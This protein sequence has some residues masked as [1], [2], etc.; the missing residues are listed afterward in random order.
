SVANERFAHSSLDD[1]LDRAAWIGIKASSP[2]PKLPEAFSGDHIDL[3]FSFY[4]NPGTPPG[5]VATVSPPVTVT[6]AS[7]TGD[8][9]RSI[10]RPAPRCSLSSIHAHI[11]GTGVF[12]LT[13]K[14]NGR[15]KNVKVLDSLD[16]ECDHVSIA[17]I[18]T[19]KFEPTT[20]GGKAVEVPLV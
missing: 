1:S 13:V 9:P 2:F 19:W 8:P 17:T 7:E 5:A 16:K 18:E 11:G 15:T 3:R 6:L 10:Y 4:Y 20:Q 14:K 12:R